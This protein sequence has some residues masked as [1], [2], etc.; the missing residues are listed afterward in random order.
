LN[1]RLVGPGLDVLEEKEEDMMMMMMMMM[2]NRNVILK[3]REDF[4]L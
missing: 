3:S 1:R 4:K 2:I